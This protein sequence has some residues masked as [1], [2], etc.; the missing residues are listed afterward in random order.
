M[1]LIQYNLYWANFS[2]RGIS[3]PRI[4]E[5]WSKKTGPFWYLYL[6][7]LVQR[8]APGETTLTHSIF[9][10]H[11]YNTR[12]NEI[13][14]WSVNWPNRLTIIRLCVTLLFAG[15]I[16]INIKYCR[17]IIHTWEI[18]RLRL[19]GTIFCLYPTLIQVMAI[20]Y[21]SWQF[22]LTHSWSDES[23]VVES[24]TLPLWSVYYR[25]TIVGDD[26]DAGFSRGVTKQAKYTNGTLMWQIIFTF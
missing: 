14:I 11:R 20:Y 15:C 17:R 5:S 2:L 8:R 3:Q 6:V 22:V 19:I 18:W 12:G 26:L 23:I 16:F 21:W 25:H 7:Q 10:L 1:P 9:N 13:T 24:G 4:S